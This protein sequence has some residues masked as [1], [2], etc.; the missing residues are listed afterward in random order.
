MK[1]EEVYAR[2]AEKFDGK[3]SGFRG[4]VQNPFLFVEPDAIVEVAKFLKEDPDCAFEVLSNLSGVDT[5]THLQVVYHLFSYK[6]RHHTVLKVN[7]PRE[8]PSVPTVEGIWPGANWMEREAYD[9]LGIVFEGHSDLRRI[10]LPEDWVG[11]PLR[12]D[13]V[14]EAEYDGISTTR[15]SPVARHEGL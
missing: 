2:L 7:T 13:Y 8:H 4:D 10:L 9:L 15:E 3:V 1:G 11:F 12:K 5:K 14:E 6:Q